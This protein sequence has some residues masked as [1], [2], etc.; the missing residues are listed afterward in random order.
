MVRKLYPGGYPSRKEIA[1]ALNVTEGAVNKQF[2]I[3]RDRGWLIWDKGAHKDFEIKNYPNGDPFDTPGRLSEEQSARVTKLARRYNKGENL[4]PDVV[5]RA[6]D[7]SPS[8]ARDLVDTLILRDYMK[9][10]PGYVKLVRLADGTPLFRRASVTAGIV[11]FDVGP[12]AVDSLVEIEVESDD[13]TDDEV[14][15]YL[16]RLEGAIAAGDLIEAGLEKELIYL[17]G[18]LG[19][20]G[21]HF[22]LRV[23]GHSMLGPPAWIADG[24]VVVIRKTDTA[25]DGEIVVALVGEEATLKRYRRV[26]GGIHLEPLNPSFDTIKLTGEDARRLRIQGRAVMIHRPL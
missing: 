24:D 22:L 5:A 16:A 11:A 1:E 18:V 2:R 8:D 4:T 26:N 15:E 10:I 14:D 19:P 7:L 13:P 3:L 12:A 25:A 6:L 20:D 17:P 21:R 23:R 9:E